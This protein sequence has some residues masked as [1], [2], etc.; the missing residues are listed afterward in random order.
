MSSTTPKLGWYKDLALTESHVYV[1]ST[2]YDNPYLDRATLKELEDQY[3]E[4]FFEQEVM[5]GWISLADMAWDTFSEDEWPNGNIHWHQYDS[6]KPYLLACD[7]GLRSA[8]IIM[9]QVPAMDKYG[10][11]LDDRPVYV[12]VGE[13]TPSNEGTQQTAA[14]IASDYGN[15]SVIYCGHDLGGGSY[16]NSATSNE[17]ELREAGF[18]CPIIAV[19]GANGTKSVQY[20][21]SRGM[22]LNT[23]GKRRFAVSQYLQSHDETKRNKRGILHVMKNDAFAEI[24]KA[25]EWLPKD[26]RTGNGYEDMR[27]AFEYAMVELNQPRAYRQKPRCNTAITTRHRSV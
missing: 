3:D 1:H 18:M 12:A 19:T 10:N 5:A 9:Q 14:R 16:S 13:Y 8:W 15:P 17:I 6:S 7:F 24:P 2:S 22:I 25:G 11:Q 26:K 27:D 21:K 4:R 20:S 23:A